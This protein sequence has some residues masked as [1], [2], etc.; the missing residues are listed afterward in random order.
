M[1]LLPFFFKNKKVGEFRDDRTFIITKTYKNVFYNSES[2]EL[3]SDL[4]YLLGKK[5]IRKIIV[6]YET[7]NKD[8]NLIRKKFETSMKTFM[9]ESSCYRDGFFVFWRAL[10]LKKFNQSN[11]NEWS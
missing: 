6:I 9:E 5:G 4:L 1:T 7:V 10:G 8:G 2:F 11:L 3:E